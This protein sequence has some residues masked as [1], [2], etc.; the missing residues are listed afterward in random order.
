MPHMNNNVEYFMGKVFDM[1]VKLYGN[2]DSWIIYT[3]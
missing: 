3:S 1:F 2:Y